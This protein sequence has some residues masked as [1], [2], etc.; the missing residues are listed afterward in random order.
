MWASSWHNCIL[1]GEFNAIQQACIDCLLSGHGLALITNGP[2]KDAW[3]LTE[4]GML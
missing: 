3:A 2:I 4:Q 1:V